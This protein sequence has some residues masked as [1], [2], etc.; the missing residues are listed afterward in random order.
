MTA[1]TKPQH[2]ITAG[3]KFAVERTSREAP[4]H[5]DLDGLPRRFEL[6]AEEV[7]TSFDLLGN[8]ILPTLERIEMR[9]EDIVLRVDQLERSH[10][11]MKDR[12]AALERRPPIAPPTARTVNRRRPAARKSK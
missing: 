9:L 3:G 6:F 11:V 8:K 12:I 7:R 1:P 5:R 10:L 2:I 4:T